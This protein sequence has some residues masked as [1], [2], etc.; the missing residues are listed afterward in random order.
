MDEDKPLG[1]SPEVIS[2]S[3]EQE[4]EEK[5]TVKEDPPKS[6]D[7]KVTIETLT[8]RLVIPVDVNKCPQFA[9]RGRGFRPDAP[10]PR[11]LGKMPTY[12]ELEAAQTLVGLKQDQPKQGSIR[13]LRNKDIQEEKEEQ[14]SD[15]TGVGERKLPSQGSSGSSVKEELETKDTDLTE[16]IVPREVKVNTGKLK[17]KMSKKIIV[18]QPE[19]KDEI[20]EL[21]SDKAANEKYL[22]IMKKKKQLIKLNRLVMKKSFKITK[23]KMRLQR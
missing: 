15:V 5:P 8:S 12:N 3:D 9:R 19:K 18:K 1:S 23:K 14:D 7:L 16:E 22:K 10:K 4:K 11:W 21:E 6:K 13:N 17:L 20:T 2:V